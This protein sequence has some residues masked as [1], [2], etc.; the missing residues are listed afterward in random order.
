MDRIAISRFKAN[1]ASVLE[2]VRR[3]GQPIVVTRFGKPIAEIVLSTPQRANR[4]IG[5]MAGTA[6]ILGDIVGP[7]VEAD[8][9]EGQR[10]K[11]NRHGGRRYVRLKIDLLFPWQRLPALIL[12]F[13]CLS[14]ILESHD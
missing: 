6:R 14:D 10:R 7:A 5:S 4:W 13:R 12:F 1:C 11:K 8:V 2:R 3:T 9:W